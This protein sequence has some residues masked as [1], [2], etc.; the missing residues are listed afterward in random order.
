MK[1]FAAKSCEILVSVVAAVTK[2]TSIIIHDH[3][4]LTITDMVGKWHTVHQNNKG[5]A[6]GSR[7]MHSSSKLLQTAGEK[8]EEG[9]KSMAKRK[10][11]AILEDWKTD[12][13]PSSPFSLRARK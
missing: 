4:M 3:C 8:A 2:Q 11:L 7:P 5:R 10:T 1:V 9:L 12:S 13:N 6:V